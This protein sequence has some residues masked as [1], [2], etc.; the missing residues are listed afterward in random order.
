MMIRSDPSSR[1]RRPCVTIARLSS[2]VRAV[3]AGVSSAHMPPRLYTKVPL[4]GPASDF[5]RAS[6]S[7]HTDYRGDSVPLEAVIERRLRV[8][9]APP[10]S[11]TE[12]L[13]GDG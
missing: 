1:P 5:G 7:Q 6:R 3:V 12:Y 4:Y 9:A 13:T 10:R 11:S 2:K 8:S